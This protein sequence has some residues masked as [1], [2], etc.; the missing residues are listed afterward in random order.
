[1]IQMRMLDIE[2]L[3]Y[4]W[5]HRTLHLSRLAKSWSSWC[6]DLSC[7]RQAALE[8]HDLSCTYLVSPEQSVLCI[9]KDT[10]HTMTWYIPSSS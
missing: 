5:S 6:L 10:N 3:A 1:M 2:S 7:T 9:I 8:R 4:L